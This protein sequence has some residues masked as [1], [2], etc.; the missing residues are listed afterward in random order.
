M[1]KPNDFF[2]I[3]LTFGG[4]LKVAAD[5]RNVELGRSGIICSNIPVRPVRIE[6][7]RSYSE[8]QHFW[9]WGRGAN[10]MGGYEA[11]KGYK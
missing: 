8:N 9:G 11:G 10:P 3:L 7:D 5:A 6:F 2:F 4:S 1:G